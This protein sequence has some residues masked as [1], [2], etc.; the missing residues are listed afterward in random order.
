MDQ[1]LTHVSSN[2]SPSIKGVQFVMNLGQNTEQ[3]AQLK[4]A[5]ACMHPSLYYLWSQLGECFMRFYIVVL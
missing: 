4:H 1:P 5:G 2:H 3:Q